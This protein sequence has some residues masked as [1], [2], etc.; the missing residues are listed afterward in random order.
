M[1]NGKT[2]EIPDE[3]GDDLDARLREDAGLSHLISSLELADGFQLDI[4]VCSTPRVA[5][6]AL[7]IIRARSTW[8]GVEPTHF[9]VLSPYSQRRSPERPL[10]S[11]TAI[12]SVLVPL[13]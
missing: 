9:D 2:P 7:R 13:I 6:A 12:Q 10:D 1:S 11:E 4:L 3:P 5:Q 8:W